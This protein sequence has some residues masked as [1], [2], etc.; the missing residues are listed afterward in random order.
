M[1]L[2][3]LQKKLKILTNLWILTVITIYLS[4]FLSSLSIGILSTLVHVK[5]WWLFPYISHKKGQTRARRGK[6]NHWLT[7]GQFPMA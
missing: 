6:D 4:P 1:E 3:E 5:K 2:I 7:W